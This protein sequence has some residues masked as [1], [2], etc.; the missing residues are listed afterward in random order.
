MGKDLKGKE[1]G[2]GVYQKPNG[3][4]VARFR[5]KTGKR[6]EKVFDKLSDAKKW[7]I[8]IKY[9][10]DIMGMTPSNITMD[11]WFQYW[12]EN[13]K[14]GNVKESSLET[15]SNL[16]RLYIKETL[17]EME[18]S[19]IKPLH[20]QNVLNLMSRRGLSNSLISQ[21]R[22]LM[23]TIFKLAME[24]DFIPK[25]PIQ[26]SVKQK[27]E[28]HKEKYVPSI[29][30]QNRLIQSLKQDLYFNMYALALQTGLRTG[31]LQ[32]LKW[33]DIN[34]EEGYLEVKRTLSRLKEEGHRIETT[35]KTKTS[36]R[37]VPLTAEAIR[38]LQNQKKKR[39]K[40]KNCCF[41]CRD[42]VF[43][44]NT[45]HYVAASRLNE[46]L[47]TTCNKL[48]IPH[49]SMHSLRH[50]FA[51]RCI[52]AGMKPKALQKI[53]GHSNIQTTMDLY[54]HATEEEIMKEIQKL[55]NYA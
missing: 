55:T 37:R 27:G 31:E 36:L 10:E 34:F 28:E 26:S 40:I 4:Y 42:Y 3:K 29:F 18:L 19:T 49:M 9:K 1:I 48:D 23:F 25:N 54:V 20:C 22:G 32:S 17:G 44:T 41:Q 46:V 21:V 50:T 39:K 12:I 7:L 24:N 30:V 51:T 35:P 45:G 13:Y 8:E 52:E 15:Y 14:T 53:L 47:N 6:P 11:R 38:I 2:E 43:V 5:S 33:E 16:Y